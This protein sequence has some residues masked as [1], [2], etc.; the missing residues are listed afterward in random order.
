MRIFRI[1][2]AIVA[3]VV[4]CSGVAYMEGLSVEALARSS[5]LPVLAI[6]T[7][8]DN[9]PGDIYQFGMMTVYDARDGALSSKTLRVKLRERGNTSRRFPKKSYRVTIVDEDGD[10]RDAALLGLRSDDDWLLNP[11]YT[12]TSKIREALAY[13]LW[14][15]MNSSGKRAQSSRLTYAEVYLNG[16]Y[17]GLYGVQERVDRKQ[18]GGDKRE[19]VLYKVIAN[20]R[21][22]VAE[23]IDCGNGERCHGIEIAFSGSRVETPWLPAAA[24][25]AYLEGKETPISVGI[26]DDNI[27]DYG[28][29][30]MLA[31]A[32]DCHFKNQFIHAAM[33]GSGGYTLYKLPWDLNNTFG[34]VWR[35]DAAENNYTDYRAGGLVMDCAF[36][37][38]LQSGDA[39]FIRSVQMRWA[40]LRAGDI[41]EET[42]I[43]MAHSLY[44]PIYDAISRDSERWPS[45]GMGSG[46]ARNIRDVEDYLR[47]A[48]T[49]IDAYIKRLS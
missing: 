7:E 27:V 17:W 36:E 46:N 39:A 2:S 15:I 33:D 45:C 49:R 1:L 28:L 16:E 26:S 31:Q 9:L 47:G 10:K 20:D 21:P 41:T 8:T 25:M 24:Y 32:H 22:T 4:L 3:V 5:G 44:D 11:L 35:N 42:L 38:R 13:R 43:S 34:D 30:A 14:D 18:V 6:D 19:S 23:L 29:W 48:F 37:M 40:E 12:D